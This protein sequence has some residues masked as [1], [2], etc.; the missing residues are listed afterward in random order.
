[1][2]HQRLNTCNNIIL[3]YY[4][5]ETDSTKVPSGKGEKHPSGICAFYILY[6]ISTHCF[7]GSEKKVKSPNIILY[8][9]ILCEV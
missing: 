1:M 3:L 5:T 9:F 2:T 6:N 4:A 7:R 8:S